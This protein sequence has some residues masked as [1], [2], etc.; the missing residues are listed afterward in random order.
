[1]K[2]RRSAAVRVAAWGRSWLAALC[3]LCLSCSAPHPAPSSGAPGP[4]AA[5]PAAAG[6][7]APS[8]PPARGTGSWHLT[9]YYTPVESYHGPPLSSIADCSGRSLGRHSSE[10]LNHVQTEGFGRL[11]IPL[12]KASYLGWDFDRH[13]WFLA[14]TPVG[15]DDRPLRAWVSMAA[16]STVSLGTS[17]R[18]DGCGSGADAGVCARLRGAAWVVAD[19]FSADPN[20]PQHLDLYVGEED[21]PDF[22]DESPNYFDVHQATVILVH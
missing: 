11:T 19:R 5:G 9:V 4:P 22:E 10:F 17:V 18:I 8:P 1:V 21:Q 6:P 3:A 13:C 20:D 16:P 15:S 12:Q 7:A 14:S 2:P